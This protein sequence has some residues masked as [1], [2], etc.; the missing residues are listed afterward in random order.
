MPACRA[1]DGGAAMNELFVLLENARSFAWVVLC[2][3]AA[4]SVGLIFFDRAPRK[5]A[6]FE[7]TSRPPQRR[8]A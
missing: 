6:R 8:A 2:A 7:E 3:V 5:D 1:G 4:V